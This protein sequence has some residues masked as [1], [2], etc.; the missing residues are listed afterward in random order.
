[1]SDATKYILFDNDRLEELALDPQI[2]QDA[3]Y[4]AREYRRNA[5][6]LERAYYASKRR[7]QD[8]LLD[9]KKK[10]F[11]IRKKHRIS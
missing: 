4:T 1:M 7:T 5:K 3:R 6:I 2:R 11:R 9:S 10:S 8:T